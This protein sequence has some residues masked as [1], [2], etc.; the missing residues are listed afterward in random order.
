MAPVAETQVVGET[1]PHDPMNGLPCKLGVEASTEVLLKAALERAGLKA[2]ASGEGLAIGATPSV[3]GTT[4]APSSCGMVTPIGRLSSAS[5][6]VAPRTPSAVVPLA[7]G[8]YQG[9]PS[10]QAASQQQ[11][12]GSGY[13]QPATISGRTE[14]AVWF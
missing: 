5:S 2:P 6:D 7:V 1:V 13:K 10:T 9:R 11:V 12:S 4:R 3:P 8:P 14:L